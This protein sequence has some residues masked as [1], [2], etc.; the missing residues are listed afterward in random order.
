MKKDFILY[1]AIDILDGKCVRLRQGIYKDV[2]VYGD[3]P[4]EMAEL[5]KTDG[6]TH[7]HI[8]DL[9]AARTGISQ[10]SELIGEIA[11]ETGLFVQTG[12]GIRDLETVERMLARG[13]QRLILGTAAIKDKD[14]TAEALRKYP[15]KIAI[16]ADARDGEIA[17]E[18]WTR[19]SGVKVGEFAAMAEDMG[20]R[21]MIFTDIATDGMLAGT[22][23]KALETLVKSV[24]M[25]IIASGGISSLEDLL[26]A[27]AGGAAGAIIGK[28]IYEGKVDLKK[29]LQSV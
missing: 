7:L 24:S 23:L 10:N 19:A 3:D 11:T 14:F 20:A 9:N 22:N 29:C 8:V 6:A 12:G 17:L 26:A 5:F 27:K 18:G 15:D 28:A 2:T 13:V 25:D 1:P 4:L 21:I 16:G